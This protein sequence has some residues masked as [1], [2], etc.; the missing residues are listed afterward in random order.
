M[1]IELEKI[2]TE[3]RKRYRAKVKKFGL[4]KPDLF[5]DYWQRTIMLG[6]VTDIDENKSVANHLWFVVGKTLSE[7]TLRTGDIISFNA[8]VGEYT[9]NDSGVW[10][11]DFKL[12]NMSKIV[13]EQR[14]T[15]PHIEG[16]ITSAN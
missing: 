15:R 11:K 16:E 9:K 12:K 4:K 2:G 13:V 8:R 7:L 6:N 1:R 5:K 14:T 3:T 10:V